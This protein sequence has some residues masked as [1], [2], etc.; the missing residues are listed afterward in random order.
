MAMHN[1][2]EFLTQ[3]SK[4]VLASGKLVPALP[5]EAR[6][7]GWLGYPGATE[8]QIAHAEARLRTTLPPSYRAFLKVTNGW[9]M[10]GLEV[11]RLWSTEEIEWFAARRPGWVEAWIMGGE[12]AKPELISDEEYFVY[13][14]EQDPAL[15]R[16]EYLRSALEISD[17]GDSAIYLL[18]PQVVT[19]EGEWETW[20]FA[21]WLPGAERYHSFGEMMSAAYHELLRLLEEEERLPSPDAPQ[22]L[23]A[24]LP[25]LFE[26]LQYKIESYRQ[27]MK[28]EAGQPF[29]PFLAQYYQS[30]VEAYQSVEIS[31]REI[32][33]QV[34][35]PQELH[36]RL[37]ELA[38]E[39]ENQGS[40]EYR[41]AARGIRWFLKHYG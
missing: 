4:D 29:V 34:Q 6:A 26:E 10:T 23:T 20:L 15:I 33:G 18:N 31:V 11:G 24:K 38:D 8:N 17:V 22:M 40:K 32:Q 12:W 21:D 7:S 9:R 19:P 5:A 30:Y 39:L 37:C 16:A 28:P 27:S 25:E 3:W 36:E 13:G 41:E 2:G 35:D 1:W 14:E